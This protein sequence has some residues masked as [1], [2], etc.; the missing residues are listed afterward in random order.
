MTADTARERD[1]SPSRGEIKAARKVRRKREKAVRKKGRTLDGVLRS[2]AKTPLRAGPSCR[3]SSARKISD[4]GV[5]GTDK[6]R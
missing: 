5:N 2:N 6:R 1:H 4:G 3:T